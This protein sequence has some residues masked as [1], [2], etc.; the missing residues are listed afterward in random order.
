MTI[1]FPVPLSP[2][3]RFSGKE[4]GKLFHMNSSE[5]F[6]RRI[7][8]G[9]FFFPADPPAVSVA[10]KQFQILQCFKY[11]AIIADNYVIIIEEI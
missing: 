9:F 11:L 4:M 10:Q 3:L 5:F 1:R 6:H 8:P 2:L 7:T